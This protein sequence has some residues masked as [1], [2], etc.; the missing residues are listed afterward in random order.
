MEHG[1]SKQCLFP[2]HSMMIWNIVFVNVYQRVGGKY[3]IMDKVLICFKHP[4]AGDK[5]AIPK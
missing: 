2:I 1:Q 4:K 5:G 3:P